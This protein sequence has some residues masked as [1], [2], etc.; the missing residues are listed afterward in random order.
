MNTGKKVRLGRLWKHER[1]VIIPFDH[2]CYSGVVS[3]LEH[4]LELTERIARTKADAILVSPGVLRAVAPALGELGVVLR[5]DG[6]LTAFATNGTDYRTMLGADDALKMGADAI[7]VF[8]FIGTPEEGPSLERL[9]RAAAS[10]EAWGIPLIAEVLAPGLLNNHFGKKLFPE[11]SEKTDLVEETKHVSRIA[12]ETGADIIKTR[13]TGDVVGFRSVVQTC[14]APVIVAGGPRVNGSDEE[15]LRL[16][17][18]CTSAGAAGIIFGRNVWQH[19]NMER[20]IDAL[21]AIVHQDESEILVGGRDRPGDD[22]ARGAR[23]RGGGQEVMSVAPPRDGEEQAARD[24]E[25]GVDAEARENEF[26][27]SLDDPSARRPGDVD[28]AQPGH[29]QTASFA[30]RISRATSISL[31]WT[32]LSLKI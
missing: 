9:G 13:Y 22:R 7:I 19:P 28:E 20:L 31:K 27:R 14:T 4:P 11:P 30:P 12:V 18:D 6:G 24:G 21:C 8:T 26:G 1:S 29:A 5:I 23:G 32:V 3:G 16:A 15:L 2:G 17:H 10:A 25:A